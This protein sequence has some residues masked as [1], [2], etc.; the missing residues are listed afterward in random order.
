MNQSRNVMLNVEGVQPG[1]DFGKVIA[2]S[3][4]TPQLGIEMIDPLSVLAFWCHESDRWVKNI[5]VIVGQ[6]GEIS[7]IRLLAKRLGELRDAPVIV[8]VFQSDRYRL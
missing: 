2:T 4:P 6:L 5:L 1:V 8:A 3:L 7:R